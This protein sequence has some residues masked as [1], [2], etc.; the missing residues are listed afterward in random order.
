MHFFTGLMVF[1]V[2]W[3]TA[4]FA[5]LPWGLQRDEN[6]MPRDPRMKRK[7]L[8]TTLVSAV[9]WV[10]VYALVKADIISFR[11]MAKAWAAVPSSG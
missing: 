10:G 1:L 2:I 11:E 3:W 4:I 7:L 6:G 8:M 5:V 9:I